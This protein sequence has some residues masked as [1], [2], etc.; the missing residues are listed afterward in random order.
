MILPSGTV[1]RASDPSQEPDLRCGQPT[2]VLTRPFFNSTSE[3]VGVSP[4]TSSLL[5]VSRLT[6]ILPVRKYEEGLVSPSRTDSGDS[7]E[8]VRDPWL[9]KTPVT[10]VDPDDQ[11]IT[12]PRLHPRRVVGE[13]YVSKGQQV[14]YGIP[15]SMTQINVSTHVSV[16]NLDVIQETSREVCVLE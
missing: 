14:Y 2:P 16:S 11:E 6:S 10:D 1:R 5:G 15:L 9:P 7:G 4:E 3:S 13:V 8:D 12:S